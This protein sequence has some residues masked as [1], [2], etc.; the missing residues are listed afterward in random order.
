[1]KKSFFIFLSILSLFLI[2]NTLNAVEFTSIDYKNQYLEPSKTYDL[3]V[4]ITP[5][6]EINNTIIGIYPYGESKDYIQ[7]IKGKDSEG[8]LFPSEKGVGHFIIKIKDDAPSKDYKIVA[9]CNYTEDNKQYSEN[10]IFTIPVR[11]APTITIEN[12]PTINEGVNKIYLKITNKGTGTAQNIKMQFNNDDNH[13]YAL[14]EGYIDHIKPGETRL[15]DVKIYASGDSIVKLPY[16]LTHSNPY[17]DLQLTDKTETEQGDS[18]TITYNY[19]NQK[20]VEET[21]NLIFKVI[22]KNVVEL[23][24]N[25]YN[26]PVG[27]VNNF[28]LSIKNNY[29][30]ANFIITIGKYYLGNNQKSLFIKHGEKENISFKTKINEIGIKEIPIK[31][32]FDGNEI[33]KNISINVIG[34]VQLVLTGVNVGGMNEKTITGDLSNIGTTKAKSVLVSI[35]RTDDIIPVRPYENYFVGTLNA[36]DYGS[37]ELHC[38]INENVSGVPIIITYRDEDN[39]LIKME[40]NISISENGQISNNENYG[41]NGGFINYIIIG[42]GVLFCIGVIYLIYRGFVRKNE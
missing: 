40:K 12:P 38:Q 10:R 16:K 23:E 33:N 6:K 18:N 11:G 9:Y 26:Y 19:K 24:V 29:K 35:K 32:I 15:M 4:V 17:D 13:I 25:K 42:I 5:E 28:T 37:F 21:G 27:E 22:P 39:N 7:I 8:Q 20:I 31:I 2:L 34:K 41:S 3:W 30:D 1:M 14:S 36:D